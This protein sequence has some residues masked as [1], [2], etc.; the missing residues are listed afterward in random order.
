VRTLAEQVGQGEQRDDSDRD[1][2]RPP[3][4]DAVPA[5]FEIAVHSRTIVSG[6]AAIAGTASPK[7]RK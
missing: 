6:I 7:D 2:Q 1:E 5:T 4:P 3:Y